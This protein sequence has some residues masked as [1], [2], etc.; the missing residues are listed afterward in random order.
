MSVGLVLQGT[1]ASGSE[2]QPDL[3][4]IQ[5]WLRAHYGETLVSVREAEDRGGR[6][7]LYVLL[8]PAAEEVEFLRIAP[9]C[10]SVSANTSTAGPGYHIYLCDL[11]QHLGAD[12]DV[13]WKPPDGQSG[14][15]TGYFHRHEPAQVYQAMLDW[16]K[17]IASI[18]AA[19][20]AAGGGQL[21]V[22]M[23]SNHHF[24]QGWRVVSPLGPLDP[25]WIE[26]V[27]EE[28]QRGESFFP[29]WNAGQDADYAFRR[30]L[31]RMWKDVRWR[32][33]LS[34]PEAGALEDAAAMLE[35]AF[36]L[37]RSREYPWR[38]W[39]ELIEYGNIA[40][41]LRDEILARAEAVDPGI[42]LIGY[43]RKD[44]RVDLTGGWSLRIPGSFAESWEDERTWYAWDATRTVRFSC[45]SITN[46]DGTPQSA[47]EILGTYV[48]IQETFEHEEEGVIGRAHLAHS[49][50]EHW[51]LH[52]RTAVSGSLAVCTITIGSE[53]DKA[54]ALETWRSLRYG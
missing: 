17:M 51:N 26:L 21:L 3:N 20:L 36:R 35:R 38:E 54:W 10:L 27:A 8:H 25:K 43:R 52:G 45:F 18:L 40:T 23:P 44:V 7:A 28:P 19:D 5:R 48:D 34:E 39:R 41:P 6:A 11:L 50:D 37:N 14:D 4:R 9:G 22:C 53:D 33:P 46:E 1:V 49:L 24:D 13:A 30:A 15:E 31:S 12:L 42:P 2:P 47:E 32:P 29:W 16:L